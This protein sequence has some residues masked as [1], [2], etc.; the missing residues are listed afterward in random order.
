MLREA[1]TFDRLRAMAP[2][3]AAALF[4]ARRAEGLTESEQ[5]FLDQWLAAADANRRAFERA[6]RAWDAFDDGVGD[7]ILAAMRA[8]A[9]AARPRGWVTWQRIAAV[10]AVLLVIVTSS[11]LLIRQPG[12]QGGPAMIE[13]ASARG[14]VREIALPDGSRMTLD[15][16]SAATGSF[17]GRE[18]MINL[19]R[20]RAFF[21]VAHDPAR[22][23]SVTAAERRV[24]ATG[25]RFEVDLRQS[26]IIVTLTEGRVTVGPVALQPGQ[27]FVERGGAT[28]IR[29]VDGEYAAAWRRGLL[30]FDDE[31]LSEAVAEVNRYSRDQLVIRA[32]AVGA[33]RISGQF[34]AGE[35]ERFARTV[36]EVHQIRLI[37]RGNV[38]ELVPR[39]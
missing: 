4:V 38:I 17:A 33:L 30:D 14:Q 36:A 12:G 1:L 19:R 22:P 2:D 10:A 39:G 27:Q 20:G 24:V 16:D 25:T 31:P 3:E 11:V 26:G 32:P 21:A 9:L 7:E 15:A 18:R 23:F 5:S 6:G 29:T 35:A 28:T 37:R 13:Y 8:H 34:R